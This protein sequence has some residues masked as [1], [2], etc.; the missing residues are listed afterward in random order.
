MPDGEAIG[1]APAQ[2][3]KEANEHNNRAEGAN[4]NFKP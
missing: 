3:R 2:E 4:G 1:T